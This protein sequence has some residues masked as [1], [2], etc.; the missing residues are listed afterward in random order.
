[1]LASVIREHIAPVLRTAPPACGIV[2]ITEVEVSPD[3]M[4]A[5]VYVSA[6]ERVE[7]AL[8]FLEERRSRLQQSL[9]GWNA[10]RIPRIRFRVDPRTERGRRMDALLP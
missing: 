9:A 1:M 2:T 3:M 5:T 4:H 6:L 10:M 7:E 8:A